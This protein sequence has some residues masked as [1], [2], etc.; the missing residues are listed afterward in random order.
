MSAKHPIEAEELM[1]YLDGELAAEHTSPVVSHLEKCSTCRELSAELRR[2]SRRLT[3]WEI[4]AP[5]SCISERVISE[6]EERERKP[7]KSTT[8]APIP[9]GGTWTRRWIRVGAVATLCVVVGLGVRFGTRNLA[10]TRTV[11][12]LR[13]VES[14]TKPQA[15][16]RRRPTDLVT[17]NEPGVAADSNGLSHGLG[18]HAENSFSADGPPLSDQRRK[19]FEGLE[20]FARLQTPPL[21]PAGPMVVHK[22]GITITVKDF[23]KARATLDDIL[24]RHNGYIAELNLNTPSGASR[25]FSSTLRVPA[26]ELD[27][28]IAELR[29]VGHVESESQS[30]EEVTDQYVDLQARL[31]NARN[32]EQRLTDLL[33][34]RTGK[35]SDVLAVETELDRVRGEIERMEAERKN[36]ANKVDYATINASV[37]E[38]YRAQL[39]VVPSTTSGQIRNAAVEGYRTVA[40]SVLAAVLFVFS[41]GPSILLWGAVV[42]FPA[43][44]AWKK[45][46]QVFDR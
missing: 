28:T 37:S 21:S 20:Q 46:H 3:L 6:I 29:N 11:S 8:I 27:A 45:R 32:T 30:G 39:Q 7:I 31:A 19:V 17:R 23:D 26:S 12:K 15:V 14:A 1:A 9:P 44:Y 10:R 41:Y 18:D 25:N 40:E 24:R 43:R 35:L 38:D 34:Q 5:E 33:R 13:G 16:S 2:V 42:F 4:D 22:A 36:L